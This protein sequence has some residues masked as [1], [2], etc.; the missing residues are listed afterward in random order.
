MN[1]LI[2]RRYNIS[3]KLGSGCFCSV[4]KGKHYK[5]NNE[6][7]IKLESIHTKVKLLQHETIILKYLYER[8]TRNIPAIYWYGTHGENLCLVMSLYDCSLYD[9][10]LS[11]KDISSSKI[12]S[13][14]YQLINILHSVHDNGVIHR[15]IKPQNIMIKNGDLYL[16]DFGFSTFY[17]DDNG[18]HS[19][20]TCTDEIIGSPKYVSYNIHCG[21]MAS[22]RVVLISVGYLYIFLDDY[23]LTWENIPDNMT[24]NDGYS[25]TSIYYYKNIIR[26]K[27][28]E[29][30]NILLKAQNTDQTLYNYLNYVYKLAYAETPNYHA[31]TRT[32]QR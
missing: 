16:I 3:Q 10:I 8:N 5:N 2:A 22:S 7:A 25:E 4:Y 13:I 26:Q 31:L 17:I 30:S 9:Y 28:K 14:I 11:K 27:M 20:D 32:F 19:A 23:F 21:S 6:V 1:E 12:K 24:A 18:E 29:P 15:D